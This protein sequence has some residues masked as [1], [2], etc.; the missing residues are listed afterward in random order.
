MKKLILLVLAVS[1]LAGVSTPAVAEVK[2]G[3][4][5]MVKVFSNFKETIEA[6]EVFKKEVEAW[7]KQATDMEAE[8]ARMGEEIQSQTLMLSAEKLEEKKLV[9]GQRMEEYQ[10]YMKDI[11]G[12]GGEA[13]RRN[14]EL[15]EPIMEKIN[16]VIGIYAKEQGFTMIFDS[17]QAFFVFAEKELDITDDIVAR[18]ETELE[19]TQ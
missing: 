9:Y 17:S 19:T 1:V 18:L 4:I 15:T 14:K 6:E 10:K 2:L 13:A 3:Y 5:D 11:F 16:G 7:R 8:L 12:E